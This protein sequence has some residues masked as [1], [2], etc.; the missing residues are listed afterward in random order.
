MTPNN[1]RTAPLNT[2]TCLSYLGAARHGKHSFGQNATQMRR[3]VWRADAEIQHPHAL[4][5][6]AL[7]DFITC[8]LDAITCGLLV[9]N[10]LAS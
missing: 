8:L 9:V 10:S 1:P 2:G 5:T 4:R 3:C 7:T 6:G